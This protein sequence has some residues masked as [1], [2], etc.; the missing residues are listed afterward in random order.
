MGVHSP[1]TEEK[2]TSD[3]K[4]LTD[5]WSQDELLLIRRMDAADQPEVSITV[6]ETIA[7]TVKHLVSQKRMQSSNVYRGTI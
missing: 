5:V 2:E 3:M 4:S 7:N 1:E 6:T